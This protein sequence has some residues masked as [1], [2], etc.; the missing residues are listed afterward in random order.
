MTGSFH[1]AVNCALAKFGRFDKGADELGTNRRE[2]GRGS[3]QHVL[4]GFY[5]N[6][7]ILSRA[8]VAID[9]QVSPKQTNPRFKMLQTIRSSIVCLTSPNYPAYFRK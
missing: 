9:N 4:D 7:R 2:C 5:F 8:Y 6:L 3:S 1:L